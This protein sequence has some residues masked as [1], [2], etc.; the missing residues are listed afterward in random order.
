MITKDQLVRSISVMSPGEIDFFLG[1]GASI[2]SGIP[3]G[4]DLV[5]YFKRLIY[6]NENR[7]SV[8][9][10]KDLYLPSTRDMLQDYFDKKGTYPPQNDPKE[11][12]YYFQECYPIAISRQRFIDEQVAYKNPSLGYLCLAELISKNKIKNIWTTNFDSL[13]ETATNIIDPQKDMLVCSS[14]NSTSI[15]NF[16]PQHPCICKL[17]GDFRYDTLQNTDEELQALEKAI[18]EYWKQSMMGRGLVV[19]GYSGNDNSI[20]NFIEDNIDDPAFLSKGLYWTVIRDGNVSQRVENLISK[21]REKGKIAEIVET[22]GFDDLLYDTYKCSGLSSALIDQQ[23]RTRMNARKPMIFTQSPIRSFIKL[24]A[25]SIA[26][27][28]KCKIFKTDITKWEQLRECVGN[29]K[30]IA[31]LFKGCIYSFDSVDDLQKAFANHIKSDILEEDVEKYIL[32]RH[33]SIYVG[34]LYDLIEQHLKSKGFVRYA[35]NRYYLPN[36]QKNEKGL[37]VYEAVELAIEYISPQLYLCLLPTVHVSKLNGEKLPKQDYQYQ[38]NQRISTMYNKEYNEKLKYWEGLFRKNGAICFEYKDMAVVFHSPATSCGG[39]NRRIEWNELNAYSFDEPIMCFSDSDEQNCSIN[40]LRGLVKYGPIDCSYVSEETA[41]TPIKIAVLSPKETLSNILKHLNGLNSQ[42]CP[43]KDAFLPNY[44]GF[45][46]I[47]RRELI[48]PSEYNTALCV[49]YPGSYFNAKPASEFVDFLKRGINNFATRRFEF[50]VL[51]IYIPKSFSRFRESS[52]ISPDFNLHDAIKLYATEKGVA[53]QFI[54]ER[55]TNSYDPCKVF[56]GL[57]TSLYAKSQGVLWHPKAIDEDTVY[58]GIGY[59]QSEKKGICIGCSQLFDSTGTGVRMILRK[60]S[61]PL[62]AGKRN[63]YMDKDEARKMMTALREKYYRCCPTS[64]IRRVVIHKTTP[65]MK[66]EIIGITQAFEGV[67]VELIQIQEYSSWRGVRFGDYAQADAYSF[68]LQRGTVVSLNEESFLL[69][70]HGCVMSDELAGRNRNYYKSG[71]GIPSPV[72]V[73]RFYGQADADVLAKEI[74]ML[75]KMNWN[76]GDSLYK[77]L[78][79]TLDFAKVLSRMSKQD[80]AIY[81]KPYDF[82]YFM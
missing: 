66:D 23:W 56:W 35:K 19:V 69:W 28:P 57:S 42:S 79:V 58:I 7:V 73:K 22:D 75:T 67:D 61:N 16:N 4:G 2:N 40:Q 53:V 20:M 6:C 26:E 38:I 37:L 70:T 51:V 41:H 14:A 52:D 81:D 71:R 64:K 44:E 45:S 82:R 46:T 9:K 8:E 43:K 25:Y 29:E 62:Y 18:Y 39:L 49:T 13:V 65:F 33:N 5:W 50:D 30:I 12:S 74:L 68:A 31:A 32:R 1:A 3:S 80:E 36:T 10:Y 21:A 72:L 76:S 11:Y 63:P 34:M 78:P 59:A 77:I 60:I 54:E 27:F 48:I 24:N 17:H 15:P 55:S 47:Y